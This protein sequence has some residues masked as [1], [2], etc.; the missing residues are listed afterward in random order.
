MDNQQVSSILLPI[1]F[2]EG[3]FVDY[4]GNVYSN[5]GKGGSIRSL[6]LRPHRGRSKS[7]YYRVKANGKDYLAHRLVMSVMVGR[8]LYKDEVV[9][10]LN[11]VT[12]DNRITNLE[13]TS[14]SGNVKHAVD[15]NLYCSGKDWYKS[16]ETSTTIP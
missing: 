2:L 5:R 6:K 11:A 8:E 14:H 7:I 4:L 13:I 9:N 10:H 16:R 1:P 15:N 3:Y 12:T